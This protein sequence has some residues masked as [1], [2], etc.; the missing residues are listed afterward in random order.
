MRE[1]VEQWRKLDRDVN[2]MTNTGMEEHKMGKTEQEFVQT[3]LKRQLKLQDAGKG[4]GN[5]P[6]PS[7]HYLMKERTEHER[8]Q[9]LTYMQEM[10]SHRTVEGFTRVSSA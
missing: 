4:F 6:E 8:K 5:L 3:E 7:T 10:M 1:M 2:V 9:L